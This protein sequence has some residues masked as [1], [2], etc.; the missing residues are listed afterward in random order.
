MDN[1]KGEKL[2]RKC[3]FDTKG[4]KY[5]VEFV[6]FRNKSLLDTISR[7]VMELRINQLFLG[8]AKNKKTEK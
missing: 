6:L 5:I 8:E 7:K 1:L 2:I 4:N 3:A